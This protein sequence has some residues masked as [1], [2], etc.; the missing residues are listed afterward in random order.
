M[1]LSLSDFAA[2]EAGWEPKA[3]ALER[4]AAALRVGLDSF[5]FF[6]DE[7][8][9]RE[10]IRQALPEVEVVE[11]PEDPSE[12]KRSLI[13][14]L[15]FEAVQVTSEDQQRTEHYRSEHHRVRARSGSASI[16]DYLTSLAMR[17]HAE[18]IDENNLDRVVQLIGK[19]N[20]FNLTTRRHGRD[21]VRAM[22]ADADSI[23]LALRMSDRFGDYGL[24]SVILGVKEADSV[25]P[26][27]RIDS[28]LM[29][30]RVI[31]RTA[32]HFLFDVLLN[33]ARE[34]G[35]SRLIGEFRPT[36]KNAQVGDLYDRLDF[37]RR[38]DSPAESTLYDLDLASAS[39]VANFVQPAHV[40]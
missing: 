28:W 22:L 34:L 40:G 38:P 31:G 37:A 14:G 2:F 1:L 33:R 16:E 32:E 11:V 35:Y 5:V 4:I 36:P 15:W 29:S 30:C 21:E 3:A 18:P 24:V 27:L 39:T 25:H 17:A 6:D 26:T 12:Y 7:P 10:Q 8:A 20:Q 23:G 13:A 9:E 19:T